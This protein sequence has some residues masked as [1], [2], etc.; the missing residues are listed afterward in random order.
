MTVASDLFYANCKE[1]FGA[2]EVKVEIVA[3]SKPVQCWGLRVPV[4]GGCYEYFEA[5]VPVNFYNVAADGTTTP[6]CVK[7]EHWQARSTALASK[8]RHLLLA[9]VELL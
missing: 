7:D 2:A 8:S 1:R 9:L 6:P 5:A 3:Y 4:Y